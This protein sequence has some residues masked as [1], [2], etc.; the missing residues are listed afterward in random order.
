MSEPFHTGHAATP[1]CHRAYIQIASATLAHLAEEADAAAGVS[2]VD[3]NFFRTR[4][5]SA[6]SL[7]CGRANVLCKK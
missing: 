2:Q 4:L 3:F 5:F 1:S 7:S 6:D